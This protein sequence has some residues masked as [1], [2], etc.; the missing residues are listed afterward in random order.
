MPAYY[1]I[2]A[3]FPTILAMKAAVDRREIWADF[4]QPGA[5]WSTFELAALEVAEKE[6]NMGTMDD[7]TASQM[8]LDCI[9]TTFTEWERT[10]YAIQHKHGSAA[11]HVKVVNL[12]REQRAANRRNDAAEQRLAA[13]MVEIREARMQKEDADRQAAE[14]LDKM[15]KERDDALNGKRAAELDAAGNKHIAELNADATM[16]MGRCA[17]EAIQ[18]VG[19]TTLSALQM[20]AEDKMNLT[21]EAYMTGVAKR[22]KFGNAAASALQLTNGE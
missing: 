15:K 22:I 21:H 14:E 9:K 19:V 2:A 13:A 18:A 7:K 10:V 8:L 5:R 17:A 12:T 6:L 16:Y 20:S 11:R 3:R 1:D 4:R